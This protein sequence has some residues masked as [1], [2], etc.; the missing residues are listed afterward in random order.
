[1]FSAP[2]EVLLEEE[3]ELAAAEDAA[4]AAAAA[5]DIV[6]DGGVYPDLSE[7]RLLRTTGVCTSLSSS[8]TRPLF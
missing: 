7:A 5:A 8:S 6:G 3:E 1:M 2:R 4:T